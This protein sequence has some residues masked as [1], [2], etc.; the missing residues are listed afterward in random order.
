M[1]VSPARA[2]LSALLLLPLFGCGNSPQQPSDAVDDKSAE[3]PYVE[4]AEDGVAS[5]DFTV[6]EEPAIGPADPAVTG[7]VPAP[8]PSL[9]AVAGRWAMDAASCDAAS[10]PEVVI[11]P[12]SIELAGRICDVAGTTEGG[13]GSLTA[14]LSCTEGADELAQTQL[15]KLVPEGDT[16]TLSFVGGEEPDQRLSRCP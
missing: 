16:L 13:D 10:G 7:A 9:D 1:P 5:P 3:S 4:Q 2:G 15:V 11:S 12:T 8:P 14:T 6:A